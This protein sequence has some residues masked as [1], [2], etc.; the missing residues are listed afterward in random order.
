MF[1]LVDIIFITIIVIG[2][3]VFHIFVIN[4]P[5][6]PLIENIISKKALEDLAK[7][8]NQIEALSI[9][10][11]NYKSKLNNSI[12]VLNN[13]IGGK[14]VVN[15]CVFYYNDKD[16]GFLASRGVAGVWRRK[17]TAYERKHKL[18]DF[19]S[20]LF[21]LS[22]KKKSDNPLFEPF[23]N[24]GI[25]FDNIYKKNSITEF[26]KSQDGNKEDRNSLR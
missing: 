17:E 7:I 2:A 6:K 15:N 22:V 14:I 21:C 9:L 13:T 20:Q 4:K 8:M 23:I 25:D 11:K 1:D 16:R 10:S 18:N 24:N 5:K 3:V 19:D 12:L 26:K